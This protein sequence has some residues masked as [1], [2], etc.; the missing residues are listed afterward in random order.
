MTPLDLAKSNP[1]A[2]RP[3]FLVWLASNLHIWTAFRREADKVWSRGR[4]HYSARTIGEVLRHESFLSEKFGEWKLNNI[5]FPDLARLYLLT[6]PNR[7]G[8]FETRSR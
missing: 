4:R 6:Y 3:G 8:F 5:R 1:A 2:F 7:A